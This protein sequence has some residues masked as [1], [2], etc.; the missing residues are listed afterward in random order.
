M[1]T[2]PGQLNARVQ[3]QV[4]VI[5][6]DN[7]GGRVISGWDDAGFLWV[8][9]AIKPD[10]DLLAVDRNRPV[11]D[12]TVTLRAH[13]PVETGWRLIWRGRRLHVRHAPEALPQA[14]YRTVFCEEEGRV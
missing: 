3:V 8:Q 1:A 4:P 6:S 12:Y 7:Q 5:S 11:F 2:D 9:I 13:H 10:G 14:L